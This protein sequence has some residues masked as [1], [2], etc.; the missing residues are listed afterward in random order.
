MV[1][2]GRRVLQLGFL[3]DADELL[4]VV[5]LAFEKGGVIW[6]WVIGVV[7]R[8]D[9]RNDG[10]LLGALGSC[11]EV[12]K[13]GLWI[14]KFDALDVFRVG[15]VA[16]VGIEDVRDGAVG[17]SRGE[18]DVA[19]LLASEADDARAVLVEDDDAD[20]EAEVL[21]ILADT[22]EI[23][24]E[25]VVGEEVVHLGC[26]LCGGLFCV[27]DKAAAVADLGVEHLAGGESLVGL[28]EV[29]DVIRHLVVGTPGDVLHPFGDEY[30]GDVVLLFEDFTGVGGEGGGFVGTGDGVDG[31][32]GEGVEHNVLFLRTKIWEDSSFRK[33]KTRHK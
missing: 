7:G 14:E 26:C 19:G 5:P 24:G 12:R 23:C 8:G 9:S 29:D 1:L 17:V 27:V 30:G 31:G 20:G 28:D 13:W 15:G 32:D 6:D 25:V 3:G 16:P 18:A 10:E 4:D 21:E 2:D 22:E 11:L 33:D